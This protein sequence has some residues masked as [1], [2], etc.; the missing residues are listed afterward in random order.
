MGLKQS[1]DRLQFCPGD[2]PKPLLFAV[3]PMYD[4]YLASYW[5]ISQLNLLKREEMEHQILLIVRLLNTYFGHDCLVNV[6]HW[7]YSL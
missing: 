4:R 6:S 7:N 1:L 3:Q 2:Y 5:T